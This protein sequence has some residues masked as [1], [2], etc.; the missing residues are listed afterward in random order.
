MLSL[1]SAGKSQDQLARV[2]FF[3]FRS[4]NALGGTRRSALRRSEGISV[5]SDFKV[6]FVSRTGSDFISCQCGI[7]LFSPGELTKLP[8]VPFDRFRIYGDLGVAGV[9]QAE[10]RPP[11][12]PS[13]KDVDLLSR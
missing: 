4:C 2:A 12:P 10:A 13:P 7:D 5:C 6:C 1:L 11:A 8:N 3:F 9:A